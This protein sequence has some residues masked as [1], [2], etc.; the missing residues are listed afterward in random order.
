MHF[1]LVS[2][3][4]INLNRRKRLACYFDSFCICAHLKELKKT[5]KLEGRRQTK[6]MEEQ[7]TLPLSCENEDTVSRKLWRHKAC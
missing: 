4:G 2:Q 1:P 7:C 3:L 6:Y 5:L